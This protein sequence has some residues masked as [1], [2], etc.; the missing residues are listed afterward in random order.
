MR[1]KRKFTIVTLIDVIAIALF[2]VAMFY[3]FIPEKK[4]DKAFVELKRRGYDPQKSNLPPVT[5]VFY[6]T[7]APAYRIGVPTTE[8]LFAPCYFYQTTD[9]QQLRH[10]VLDIGSSHAIINEDEMGVFVGNISLVSFMGRKFICTAI[11]CVEDMDIPYIPVG[12]D[13]AFIPD[14]FLIEEM[15]QYTKP[16]PVNFVKNV[17]DSIF[18]TGY[19]LGI[20]ETDVAPVTIAGIGE[21]C[22]L[23]YLQPKTPA[24]NHIWGNSV[25]IKMDGFYDLHGVSGSPAFNKDGEVVGVASTQ[26]TA[27]INGAW[28]MYVRISLFGK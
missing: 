23:K 15:E 7:I 1:T 10:L 2:M 8:A 6:D 14:T 24:E 27:Y 19:F 28:V 16:F 20:T 11:H 18:V 12:P 5:T 13:V 3:F 26:H 4:Q 9:T 22:N 25:F 17:Y 21:E